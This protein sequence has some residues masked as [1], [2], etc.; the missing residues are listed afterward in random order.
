MPLYL[1]GEEGEGLASLSV[2][3]KT[4]AGP[5]Q[6]PSQALRLC[7]KG[8]SVLCVNQGPYS[9][10]DDLVAVSSPF[11]VSSAWLTS[12]HTVSTQ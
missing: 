6:G 4:Q 8:S 5:I 7:L 12:W 3:G 11:A 1:D 9:V 2:A 10:T